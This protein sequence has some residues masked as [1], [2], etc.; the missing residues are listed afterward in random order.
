MVPMHLPPMVPMNRVEQIRALLGHLGTLDITPVGV[1]VAP[2]ARIQ[3]PLPPRSTAYS[4]TLTM[5]HLLMH[6]APYHMKR[7]IRHG[8]HPGAAAST[9]NSA[10]SHGRW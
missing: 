4:K 10:A 2:T 3:A 7:V 5:I 1:M 8:P 6:H 9:I